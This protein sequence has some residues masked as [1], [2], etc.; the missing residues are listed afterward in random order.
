MGNRCHIRHPGRRF[1]QGIV[2]A[3]LLQSG[4]LVAGLPQYIHDKR[5]PDT[6]FESIHVHQP[7]PLHAGRSSVS[8]SQG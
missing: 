1:S 5:L 7:I 6:S 4:Y 3:E 8:Y 2:T